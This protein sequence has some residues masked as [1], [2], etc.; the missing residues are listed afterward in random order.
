MYKRQQHYCNR[1][2]KHN[3]KNLIIKLDCVQFKCV[4]STSGRS[5]VNLN[6][7]YA[8]YRVRKRETCIVPSTKAY[9]SLTDLY[10]DNY[11]HYIWMG[12]LFHNQVLPFFSP[13]K[14]AEGWWKY[15]H[16]SAWQKKTEGR[17]PTLE[18]PIHKISFVTNS[19][20]LFGALLYDRLQWKVCCIL[21]Y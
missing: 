8:Y 15:S 12:W 10:I 1:M 3:S 17:K 16:Y 9:K 18:N 7:T 11:C 13:Q 2:L 19:D 20:F 14:A 6:Q 4:S 21:L 5:C